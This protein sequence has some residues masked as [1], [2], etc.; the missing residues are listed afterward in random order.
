[1]SRGD[2]SRAQEGIGL[3]LALC[4]QLAAGIGARLRALDVEEGAVVEL[5][6]AIVS[7]Q[8]ERAQPVH[9]PE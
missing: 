9:R 3:G 4:Q 8:P 6:L 2:V 7:A 1:M 5:S